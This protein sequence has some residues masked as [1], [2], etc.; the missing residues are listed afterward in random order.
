MAQTH[1]LKRSSVQNKVPTAAQLVDGEVAINTVNGQMFMVTNVTVP[2]T[3]TVAEVGSRLSSLD[4]V[5]YTGSIGNG[6]LNVAGAAVFDGGVTVADGNLTSQKNTTLGTSAAETL[7]VNA[8]ST[9]NAPITS[10][11]TITQNGNT[12]LGNAAV[13]TLAVN[14]T[15]TFNAPVTNNSTLTQTGSAAFNSATFNSAAFNGGAVFNAAVSFNSAVAFANG[16]SP[17]VTLAGDVTG[18]ATLTN[19][20]SATITATVVEANVDHDLLSNFVANEHVNHTTVSITAGNGLTGGGTIAATRTLNVGA[21]NGITVNADDVAMSGSYTGDF[22][23]TGN[24]TAYSDNRLKTDLNKIEGALEKLEQLT[25][26]TYTRID[27]GRRETGLIAQDVEKVLPEAV[28][29]H[30]DALTLAY[31]NMLGLIVESIKELSAEV[32]ALKQQLK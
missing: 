2:G 28:I 8:T 11:S 14:A 24:I 23:A 25:G 15:S 12:T 7:T 18:N 16:P 32:K 29:E 13:D 10:S 6:H 31:G 27:T 17:V 22:T 4:I 21:G 5:D 3:G 26:Y 20:N 1:L 9:F 30:E 19:L